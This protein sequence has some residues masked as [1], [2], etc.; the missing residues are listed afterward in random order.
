MYLPP[1]SYFVRFCLTPPTPPKIGH[2]LC[3]FPYVKFKRKGLLMDPPVCILYSLEAAFCYVISSPPFRQG[4]LIGIDFQILIVLQCR[5]VGT[6]GARGQPPPP[7]KKGQ[8]LKQKH[9]LWTFAPATQS[10][11]PPRFSDLPT[12]L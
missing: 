10:P 3:T 2:H 9:L 4:M 6:A 8:K 11:S 7:K 12:A 1:L 5:V